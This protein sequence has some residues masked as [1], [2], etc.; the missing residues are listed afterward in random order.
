MDPMGSQTFFFFGR[1]KIQQPRILVSKLGVVH[2]HVRKDKE[3]FEFTYARTLPGEKLNLVV[4]SAKKDRFKK[5]E[6]GSN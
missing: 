4:G 2:L 1:S 6:A 5:S 3:T